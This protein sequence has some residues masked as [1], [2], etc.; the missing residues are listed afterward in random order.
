M[1]KNVSIWFEILYSKLCEVEEVNTVLMI[2]RQKYVRQ[3]WWNGAM[4]FHRVLVDTKKDVGRALRR[5]Y[6]HGGN[7]FALLRGVFAGEGL[8]GVRD[9]C[10]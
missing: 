9:R 8:A 1:A 3:A 7:D 4:L 6:R 5:D 2:S 10:L